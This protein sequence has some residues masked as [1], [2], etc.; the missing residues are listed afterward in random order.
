MAPPITKKAEVR[1]VVG[2]VSPFSARPYGPSLA[3]IPQHERDEFSGRANGRYR[4]CS[5]SISPRLRDS[6][7][8]VLTVNCLGDG[9]YDS[10]RDG[11]GRQ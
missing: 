5:T 10:Y 4:C 9:R 8:P 7:E 1:R 2:I 3:A 11:M 6:H